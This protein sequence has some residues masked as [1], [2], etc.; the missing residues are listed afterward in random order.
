[1]ARK[2]KRVLG[3]QHLECVGLVFDT[4]TD[5][6]VHVSTVHGTRLDREA[7]GRQALRRPISCWACAHQFIPDDGHAGVCP[8]CGRPVYDVQHVAVTS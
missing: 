8:E 4:V 2:T 5:R 3:C 1:M 7:E 6:M